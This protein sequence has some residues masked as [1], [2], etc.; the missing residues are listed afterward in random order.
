MS[1][2]DSDGSLSS[3]PTSRGVFA[4]KGSDLFK[5]V[6]D[7]YVLDESRV[8]KVEFDRYK[9]KQQTKDNNKEE[10]AKSRRCDIC[11]A[12]IAFCKCNQYHGRGREFGHRVHWADE[13]WDKPLTTIF[14][15]SNGECVNAAQSTCTQTCGQAEHRL[16][17][18]I[19]KH[20]ATC[21][22][23]VSN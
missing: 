21:I 7:D 8:S 16:P 5:A 9:L 2:D 11:Q 23:I 20:R 10:H 1:D 6:L 19:L 14:P 15:A 17:K 12:V 3:S 13:V 18:P 22:V 4:S